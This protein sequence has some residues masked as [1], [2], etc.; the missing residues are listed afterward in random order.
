MKVTLLQYDI[1]FASP[2]DNIQRVREMLR[3][4][5]TS[6]LYVLP[7]LWNSGFGANPHDIGDELQE[8]S[9]RFMQEMAQETNAAVCGSMSVNVEKD[10]RGKPIVYANRF[11]FVRPDGGY[12][13]YDK[14][15]LFS[16]GDEDKWYSAGNKRVIV[17]WRGWR[18]MPLVCYD[19]RF[20][21]WIRYKGDYD[22]VV[23]VANWHR[24]RIAAWDVLT[25]ARAIENQC[26]VLACN[27]TGC[28]ACG[29]Y[30][31]HS[32]IIS[33]NGD[34]IASAEHSEQAVLT[35]ELSL[36]ELATTRQTYG[37]LND[38]DNK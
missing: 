22:A 13:T 35:A 34:I 11:Y 18:I 3:Q 15:H 32:A 25:R 10:F 19:L 12:D 14:H 29:E 1:H 17:E 27:R 38:R 26:C 37:F 30:N 20:P 21:C 2:L 4:A 31:G 33:P 9:L 5:E 36:E 28:D 7:E 23:V 24:D 8:Q 16:Y 6:D